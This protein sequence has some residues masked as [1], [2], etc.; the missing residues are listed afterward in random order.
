M[1]AAGNEV[2]KALLVQET[3]GQMAVRD[4]KVL[5]E[6]K[7]HRGSKERPTEEPRAFKGSK[8]SKAWKGPKA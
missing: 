6:H 7:E 4:P 1:V 5:T 2:P 8:E 3:W